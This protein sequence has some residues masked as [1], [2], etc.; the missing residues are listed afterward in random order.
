MGHLV[1]VGIGTADHEGFLVLSSRYVAELWRRGAGCLCAHL[2]PHGMSSGR[3]PSVSWP[4][5]DRGGAQVVGVAD[6]VVLARLCRCP[7][8]P[9][10]RCYDP[11]STDLGMILTPS[12]RGTGIGRV[13]VC[14]PVRLLSLIGRGGVRAEAAAGGFKSLEACP[15]LAV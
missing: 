11:V 12:A 10:T 14:R 5:R 13:G 8:W 9:V 15:S 4:G 7:C 1:T 2:F 6:S 3:T